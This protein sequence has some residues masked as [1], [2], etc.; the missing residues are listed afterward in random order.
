MSSKGRPEK[1][2]TMINVRSAN[3]RFEDLED[4]IDKVWIAIYD[5]RHPDKKVRA[6][7]NQR[8]RLR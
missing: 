1:E 4:Q 2:A 5:L 6:R 8:R 7:K 3:K